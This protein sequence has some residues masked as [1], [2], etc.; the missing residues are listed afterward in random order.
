[1]GKGVFASIL[2]CNTLE[3]GSEIKRLL[4]MGIK[5]IHLDLMDG[6]FVE[7][8]F[9]GEDIIN[10]I[11]KEYKD[12]EIECHLM[13]SDPLK[14]IKN[15]D[16]DF[17]NSVIIH[18]KEK[19][20][21]IKE[22]LRGSSCKLGIAVLH[23]KDIQDLLRYRVEIDK[24]LVM[25]VSPGRGGQAMLDGTKGL[26]SALKRANTNWIVG[27]DGGVNMRTFENVQ[28]ADDIVLGSCIYDKDIQKELEEFIHKHTVK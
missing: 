11:A 13:V 28:E 26:V 24:I 2:S 4:Q 22:Y 16:V 1:M 9:L 6:H 27:V 20:L 17:I 14:V 21:E 5:K 19:I 25:G 8:I 10:Q 23:E 7:K 18:Q 15:L 12:V 3:I